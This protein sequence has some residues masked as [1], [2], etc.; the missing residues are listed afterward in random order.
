MYFDE[1]HRLWLPAGSR[2]KVSTSSA[3]TETDDNRTV[4]PRLLAVAICGALASLVLLLGGNLLQKPMLESLALVPVLFVD[5][6]IGELEGRKI[7]FLT[8]ISDLLAATMRPAAVYT[9]LLLVASY[10]EGAALRG[11][12]G[13]VS[14]LGLLDLGTGIALG[15]LIGW[16]SPRHAIWIILETSFV[17]GLL[18]TLIDLALLH[19]EQ[20]RLVHAGASAAEVILVN[21]TAFAASGI[22][23]YLAPRVRRL[24]RP[25]TV[26]GHSAGELASSHDPLAHSGKAPRRVGVIG[27]ALLALTGVA[28][29]GI[30][31]SPGRGDQ[32]TPGLYPVNRQISSASAVVLT[33]TGVQVAKDGKATFFITYSNTGASPQLLTC[34]GYADPSAAAITPSDGHAVHSVATYCSDHPGHEQE[35]TSSQPLM[36]YAIFAGTKG[37]TGPF[38]FHWRAGILSGTISH[39]SLSRYLPA[40]RSA[41]P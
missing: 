21:G 18:G 23:G 32:L 33:L 39:V 30:A 24:R 7:G 1:N 2:A 4:A 35:V 8:P 10:A 31:S 12:G 6:V 3:L 29:Y 26:A 9:A 11:A 14:T 36:S 34:A 38:T 20:F 5:Y 15:A 40:R 19:P 37:L 28:A 25:S 22:L 41:V 13:S 17:A 16:R 27:L